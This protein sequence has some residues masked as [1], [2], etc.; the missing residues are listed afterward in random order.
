MLQLDNK[1]PFDS[2]IM[3]T[4][5]PKGAD[6]VV[7]A[8]KATFT[9]SPMVSLSAE[10]VPLCL[11]DK[12]L[13]DPASSSLLYASEMLLPKPGS[14]VILNGHAY[15][16]E[17]QQVSVIDTYLSIGNASK[18]V[19]AFGDRLWIH[20]GQSS[21]QPFEKMALIYENAF[22]GVHHFQPDQPIGPDS[23]LSF[24]QNPLGLGF[25]GT[26]QNNDMIGQRLPNLEDPNFLIR[27]PQDKP[28]PATYGYTPGAWAPRKNYAGTYDEL[29]SKTRA[30][31][32]PTDFDERFFLNGST[33]LSFERSTFFGG[34]SV[35]LVNLMKGQ[36]DIQFTLPV[37]PIAA[38]FKFNGQWQDS[39]VAI[40]T[41]L[42][43]PDEN[44]FCLIW[45]TAFNC[46]K[47]PLKV[48]EVRVDVKRSPQVAGNNGMQ[49]MSEGV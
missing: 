5:D 20:G 1:T 10:Q 18:T 6:V 23:A 16:P 35:R 27:T 14:D 32:L 45:K 26:R 36:P 43:E 9:L 37:C 30:P 7:L 19:R 49:S 21:P 11:E 8:V 47:K 28:G 3:L 41:I 25:I 48:S 38:A 42:I 22:G 34:E 46:N 29:W 15:A 44:R 39:P 31:F 2:Q 24:D 4:T 33:N 12:Y 17:G 40:E 13:G